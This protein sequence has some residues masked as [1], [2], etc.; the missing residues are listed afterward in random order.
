MIVVTNDEGTSGVPETARLLKEG[1]PALDAVE[2]G[3]RL[4]EADENVR[5]VGRGGWPN[6]LGE[7][8]LDASMMDGT[9]L[10]TGAVGALKGFLHPVSV[11]RQVLERLPH[12]MLV[13]EGAARFATEIG[14]E[15]GDLLAPHA[16]AA[17]QAWFAEEVD[18]SAKA[19]WP[20]VPLAALCRQSIDPEIGQ[21]TTVFLAADHRGNLAAGTS[22]SGWGWKYPGRLG[23]SPLIGAGSYADSRYGA[24]ACTGAGEMAI[25]A[26]T[27]RAVVAYMK[28]GMSV[29]AA[30]AEAV[31]DMRALKGGIISRITIHAVD[32]RGNHKVVAVN[33]NPDNTYWIWTPERT[34]PIRL[35]AEIVPIGEYTVK[36]TASLRYA[37]LKL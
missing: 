10:R 29:A 6:L 34:T 11:A 36:P 25:R 9:T 7:V 21:D 18:A 17:W 14:A 20:N 35:P 31:E 23:D 37:R 1:V 30:V 22:T 32:T 24:C 4:V 13:G 16:R 8:E 5:T 33:G 15:A 2:A 26:G 28:M 12:E 27:A 19:R 3:I